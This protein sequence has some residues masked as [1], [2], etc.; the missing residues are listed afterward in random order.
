MSQAD[1]GLTGLPL[2]ATMPI[3]WYKQIR[4]PKSKLCQMIEIKYAVI[5]DLITRRTFYSFLGT[6]LPDGANLITERHVLA[7]K[8]DEGKEERCIYIYICGR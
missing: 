1:Q 4:R 7:L 3:D 8:S 5:R 6:D 2:I